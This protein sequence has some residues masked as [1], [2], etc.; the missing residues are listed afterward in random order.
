MN[1]IKANEDN[2]LK[3]HNE[4]TEEERKKKEQQMNEAA[5]ENT[6]ELQYFT[7]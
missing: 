6:G 1:T 3:F 2:D 4:E 7:E 5:K